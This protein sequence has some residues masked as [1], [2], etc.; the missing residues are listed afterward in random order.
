[1][2]PSPGTATGST[3]SSL[4]RAGAV[5]SGRY[6]LRAP[7]G[8]GA[9]GEV[10]RAE[11]VT[12]GTEVAVK[13]VDTANRDDAQ[14]TLARF[15]LEARAAAQLK[16]PHVVQI[17]DYGADG[18]VAFIAMEY[19]EG[20]SLEQRIERRGW[21]LPSEVAHILREMA[22]AVDRAHAAGIIHRDLKPPN[23]FLARVDGMEV[24]K[25]LDFGIAKMLGQ[26]REAHLQTQAGFVV[27]TPAYMSPEQ[28]LGKSVDHRSDLW[29]MAMI[30]FECMTGRRP[31]DGASLG[32]LFMAI[33]TLPLPVPSVFAATPPTLPGDASQAGAGGAPPA[34]APL[35]SLPPVAQVPP[36][37]DAWFARAASRDPA[38]RFQ[39]A[40]EMTEALFTILS[41]GGTGESAIATVAS[42]MRRPAAP[43][44]ALPTGRNEAWSTGRNEAAAAPR[45]TP[46]ALLA[47]LIAAPF[48]ILCVGLLWYVITHRAA[49]PTVALDT[50]S[51]SAS[52]Q[53][54]PAAPGP[55][56]VATTTTTATTTATAPP[57][58]TASGAPTAG[59]APAPP[60]TGTRVQG[61]VRGPRSGRTKRSVDLGI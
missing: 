2:Q 4:W 53:A 58:A 39:S 46:A 21:L 13:L 18:R 14:E 7:I 60:A 36:A 16:S 44:A 43:P 42:P 31:F 48:G 23:V 55:S 51:G 3:K 41:P 57:A 54:T 37:F 10:W 25:V 45:A 32:Q 6:R 15:Q 50:S 19:L 9:M 5:V 17:L 27:G 29:Q 8:A 34:R 33:C 38:Q 11:H 22:R 49:P 30:A 12:L 40:G 56:A 24:V 59:A 52:A 20:E 35:G 47:A 1:V 28:V 26:P 61:P